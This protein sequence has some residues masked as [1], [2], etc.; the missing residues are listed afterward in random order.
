MKKA[1]DILSN[2]LITI[3]GTI[4]LFIF[5]I[6]VSGIICRTFL[7]FSLLW[8]DDLCNLSVAWMLAFGMAVAFH[9]KAHLNI[10][11]IR[12]KMP[13]N[14]RKVLTIV[15]NLLML[16]FLISL[17]PTGWSTVLS[18]MGFNYTVLGVPTAYSFIAIPVFAF[19]SSIFMINRIVNMLLSREE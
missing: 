7:G 5:I 3:S 16:A 2:V 19:F 8:E 6:M 17:I 12:E 18:K 9:K 1:L 15:L 11:F 14:V 13:K 10:E 4:F